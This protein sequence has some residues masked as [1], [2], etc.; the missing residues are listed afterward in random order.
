[1]EETSISP[2]KCSTPEPCQPPLSLFI[3][4]ESRP[5]E[6][7][8]MSRVHEHSERSLTRSLRPE[9]EIVTPASVLT[10]VVAWLY[11]TGGRAASPQKSCV[12]SLRVY[13]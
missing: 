2:G 12:Y 4:D 5:V 1:M 3:C 11:I 13:L 9:A 8:Y 7:P 10:T 6:A